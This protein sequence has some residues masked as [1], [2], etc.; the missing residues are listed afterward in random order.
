MTPW[1]RARL[2]LDRV[3]AL[4]GA[5]L[6]APLVVAVALLI[7]REDGGPPLIAVTRVGRDGR[8]FRMW[9]LRSM[10]TSR[11]DGLAPGPQ[12][13]TGDDPRITRIGR[14]I[15][16]TH[17][18]ELPQL[19]N[20][21]KGDMLLL[22]PRPE[23]PEFVD[24]DSPV[25]RIVLSVPPGIAGP[26]QVIVNDW[27]REVISEDDDSSGYPTK[28]LPV[29]LAIDQWYLEHCTPVTDVL[30]AI[31]LV[32]RFLPGTGSW[33]LKQRVLRAVPEARV[34]IEHGAAAESAPVS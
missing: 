28:V 22:G 30:V 6:T 7:R 2:V 26:T 17:V 1:L 9:K 13:T 32:R 4:V 3:V 25:W 15:R 11:A 19:L 24:L 14:R 12:L 16:S 21:V 33:T 27:E 10:R 8:P 18:D 5:I 29:K 20:V 34:P 23:A 31:T